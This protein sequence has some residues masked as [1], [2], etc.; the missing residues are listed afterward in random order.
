VAVDGFLP[1]TIAVF[2]L[3]RYRLLSVLELVDGL[4]SLEIGLAEDNCPLVTGMYEEK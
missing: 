3:E 4:G 1:D 2:H